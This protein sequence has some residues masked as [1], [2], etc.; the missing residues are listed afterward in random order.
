MTTIIGNN[1]DNTLN[2]TSGSD[3]IVAKDGD[4]VINAG[5]GNDIINAGAGNDIINAGSGND[6]VIAGSG[7]DI[8]DAGSGDDFIIAGSGNDVIDGGLGNDIIFGDSGNDTIMFSQGHDFVDGGLG[9]DRIVFAGNRA[10]FNIEVIYPWNSEHNGCGTLLYKVTEIATGSYTLFTRIESLQFADVTVTPFDAAHNHAPT[11]I[12]LSNMVVNENFTGIVGNLAGVDAET[13]PANMTYSIIGGADAAKFAL[14]GSQLV[15][16][17]PA[18]YE[19]AQSLQVIIQAKDAGGLIVNKTFTIGVNDVNEAPNLSL[20]QTHATSVDEN[21][22]A[23]AIATLAITDPDTAAAFTDNHYVLSGADADKFYMDVNVLMLAGVN[24]ESLPAGDKTLDVTVIAVDTGDN[25]LHSDPQNFS[26]I[27]NDVNEAGV[28]LNGSGG[29]DTLYGGD[30]DDIINANAG[31]DILYGFYGNDILNGGTGN[32]TLVGGNGDDTLNGNAGND[33]LNGNAG[34][35]TLNGGDGI[36]TANYSSS[37][38]AVNVSLVAGAANTGGDAEDDTFIF[39]GGLNTVEQILG[40]SFNDTLT[41]ND[42]DNVLIGNDGDDHLNGG[43]GNDVLSGGTGSDTFF[44]SL[45]NEGNDTV[46][47]GTGDIDIIA[48]SDIALAATVS[49][50]L[51]SGSVTSFSDSGWSF[52]ADAAGTINFAGGSITFDGIEQLYRP[53]PPDKGK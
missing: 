38:S 43:G 53:V 48:F 41:G 15:L 4:D 50:N 35:D 29:N 52:T 2:G 40:S 1:L 8:V 18:D 23:T 3:L 26:V 16:I 46:H 7:N 19:T 49:F 10:A 36:D 24:Y 25:S 28:I 47:G 33:F 34:A 5:A 37:A 21:N 45:A 30:G 6:L 44:Y 27:I 20:V 17:N 31:N 9:I 14:S 11:D 39:S 42:Q 12:L 32:D 51:T 13:L 22:A